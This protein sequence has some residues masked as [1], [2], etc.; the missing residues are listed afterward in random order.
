[1]KRLNVL[2]RIK[3]WY[4]RRQVASAVSILQTLDTTMGKAGYD[5]STRKR[6]WRAMIKDRSEVISILRDIESSSTGPS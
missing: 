1:M 6:F 3:R 2:R 4:Y 5:R